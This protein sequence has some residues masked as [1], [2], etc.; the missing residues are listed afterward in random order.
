M[1]IASSQSKYMSKVLIAAGVI[2]WSLVAT[3][4][5]S[6]SSKSHTANINLAPMAA[7]E[8]TAPAQNPDRSVVPSI[9]PVSSPD[10][11]IATVSLPTSVPY[12]NPLN[13]I[14]DLAR[15]PATKS[16]QRSIEI[17]CYIS[18]CDCRRSSAYTIGR[19]R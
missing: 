10:V 3:S 7:A 15:K 8:Q 1:N 13:S 2:G 12:V 16:C 4:T 18:R 17:G 6:C 11:K 5:I 19:L 9:T 14:A